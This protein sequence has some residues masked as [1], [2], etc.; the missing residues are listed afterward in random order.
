MSL[1]LVIFHTPADLTK[2]RHLAF[3]PFPTEQAAW[4]WHD[5]ACDDYRLEGDISSYQEV[6]VLALSQ[7]RNPQ[8]GK[9]QATILFETPPAA[10][11][12]S[13]LGA[14]SETLNEAFFDINL[15][16]VDFDP[17]LSDAESIEF[18]A[19]FGGKP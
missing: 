7:T 3:G 8:D 9:R 2:P 11:H 17:P 10:G 5:E 4:T 16:A 15:T 6:E 14:L 19:G 18:N 1:Y 12:E 13:S